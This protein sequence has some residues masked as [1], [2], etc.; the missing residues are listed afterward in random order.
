[1][2]NLDLRN[3]GWV[4]HLQMIGVRVIWLSEISNPSGYWSF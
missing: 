4:G 2:T 1:M 3:W